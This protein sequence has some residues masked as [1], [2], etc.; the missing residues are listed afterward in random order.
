MSDSVPPRLE[1]PHWT[2]D[3]LRHA[4]AD[5]IQD[6]MQRG[7]TWEDYA[8]D[9]PDLPESAWHGVSGE[10]RQQFADKLRQVHDRIDHEDAGIAELRYA[11]ADLRDVGALCK[12]HGLQSPFR[13]RRIMRAKAPDL[14]RDFQNPE[15][16]KSAVF[17]E[18][19][20]WDPWD[21]DGTWTFLISLPDIGGRDQLVFPPHLSQL[22]FRL[23]SWVRYLDA[24]PRQKPAR[25]LR[26]KPA[27][28][29]RGVL[30]YLGNREYQ[31]GAKTFRVS[32]LQDMVLQSFIGR[33]VQKADDF[34]DTCKK[35]TV[36]VPGQVLRDLWNKKKAFRSVIH[37]AG[38]KT[39]VG[40]RVKVQIP[41][42]TK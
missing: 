1:P 2:A 16:P 40:Y 37:L 35:V 25:P 19:D 5:S 38:D 11:L 13:Q 22:T 9:H 26:Q 21:T 31:V 4:I 15:L 17:L 24:A 28:P 10:L 3:E 30:W 12:R 32:L 29:P 23:R 34:R 42:S 14:F 39:S 33:P 27:R 6:E 20:P 7:C 41:P 8:A 36:E 18:V